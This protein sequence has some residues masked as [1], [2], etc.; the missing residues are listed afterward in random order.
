MDVSGIIS[1]FRTRCHNVST[2]AFNDT[3]AL[4]LANYSYQK[5][6]A[7]IRSEVNEDFMSDIWTRDTVIGQSEYSFDTRWDDSSLVAPILKITKVAIK[8]K[9]DTDYVLA[10]PIALSEMQRDDTIMVQ[11]NIYYP[12]YRFNDMSINLFPA[13]TEVV[14]AWLKV[15]GLYNPIPLTLSTVEANIWVPPEWHETITT[16]MRY[17]YYETIGQLDKRAAAYNDML[18]EESRMIARMS[19]RTNGQQESQLPNLTYFS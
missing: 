6:I 12:T 13:P 7:T 8:Y 4:E 19:N 2:T 16:H 5:V 1:L 17:M 9:S 11:G 3:K 18:E 15:Y 10:L 14:T